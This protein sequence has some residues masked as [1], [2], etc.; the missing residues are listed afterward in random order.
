MYNDLS[1]LLAPTKD[2][3]KWTTAAKKAVEKVPEKK[4]TSKLQDA[5]SVVKS[6]LTSDTGKGI[7]KGLAATT[8]AA[9]IGGSSGVQALGGIM[10]KI[11][12][13][14]KDRDLE[15]VRKTREKLSGDTA[16]LNLEYATERLK[17]QKMKNEAGYEP[18]TSK[19]KAG[20]KTKAA[21]APKEETLKI[22][23]AV[24]QALT[25]GTFGDPEKS[26]E[27]AQVS[28]ATL[29]SDAA[30]MAG[31]KGRGLGPLKEN[32]GDISKMIGNLGLNPIQA[33][34]AQ[35]GMSEEVAPG[36]YNRQ[37]AIVDSGGKVPGN[38][39]WQDQLANYGPSVYGTVS[40]AA[41]GAK[42]GAP[43]GLP[44]MAIGGLAGGAIG[45]AI[46]NPLAD[47]M[48][49]YANMAW[50][51]NPDTQM[52][53]DQ[54]VKGLAA[55]G[56]SGGESLE[57]AILQLQSM[58]DFAKIPEEQKPLLISHLRSKFPEPQKNGAYYS[59][60]FSTAAR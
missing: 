60:L 8:A 6:A 45:A 19:V 46:S 48:S 16:Q 39:S 11:E 50:V 5:L 56:V 20:L 26:I 30:I 31:L 49:D 23:D 37:K 54:L 29:G 14:K 12:Q 34:A 3:E 17:G 27:K 36:E 52:F 42:M 47:R 21:K 58:P 25:S 51:M 15:N 7:L 22:P 55:S 9:A 43:A 33:N 10:G 53:A 28:G 38:E 24:P 2:E 40:G 57:S 35:R 18:A 1:P 41:I 44:G 13:N 32:R 59:G 4:K